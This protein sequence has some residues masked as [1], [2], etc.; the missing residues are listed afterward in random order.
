M[1]EISVG[2]DEQG[3]SQF[4]F[5]PLPGEDHDKLTGTSFLVEVASSLVRDYKKSRDT[6]GSVKK[7]RQAKEALGKV[8]PQ[9]ASADLVQALLDDR[10]GTKGAFTFKKK[11]ERHG[12]KPQSFEKPGK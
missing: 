6:I 11:I 9:D 5:R 12:F 8:F 10:V 1:P 3:N 2:V 4:V 7:I